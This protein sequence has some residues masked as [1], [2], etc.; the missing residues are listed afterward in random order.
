M[1]RPCCSLFAIFALVTSAFAQTPMSGEGTP[2]IPTATESD[3]ARTVEKAVSLYIV[4]AYG[5]LDSATG[6][7]VSSAAD[8]CATPVPEKADALRDTFAATVRAWAGVDFSASARWRRMGATSASPSSPTCTAS[9][10]GRSAASLSP[11]TRRC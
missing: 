2:I 7:L 8:F 9:A 5:D 11:K 4:P 3:Y 1:L 10:R 6:A